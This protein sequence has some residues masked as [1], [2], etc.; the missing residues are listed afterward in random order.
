MRYRA[1]DIAAMQQQQQAGKD[2]EAAAAA[3][4]EAVAGRG[5]NSSSSRMTSAV[6]SLHRMANG[7]SREDL[8]YNNQ[9]R[10]HCCLYIEWRRQPMDSS[11]QDLSIG[12]III[13]DNRQ[14]LRHQFE[15]DS[16]ATLDSYIVMMT[17]AKTT[18][19]SLRSTVIL[20][21]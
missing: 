5:G 11:H 17:T 15:D 14:F 1:H 2:E 7:S 9:L 13:H 6:I 3:A 21:S 10:W 20:T 12:G 18:T 19:V 4:A 16:L 8:E